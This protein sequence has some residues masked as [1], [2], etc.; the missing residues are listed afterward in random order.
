MNFSNRVSFI[1]RFSVD[2]E[3]TSKYYIVS[4][5][6]E[7]TGCSIASV[8]TDAKEQNKE[9]DANRKKATI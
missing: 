9:I 6:V 8:A 1:L 2:D 3:L 4:I 5:E 7:N